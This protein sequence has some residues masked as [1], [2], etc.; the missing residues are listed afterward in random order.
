ML[1]CHQFRV[2]IVIS[3][4]LIV[5]LSV[6]E[7]HFYIVQIFFHFLPFLSFLILL[8]FVYFL[9]VVWVNILIFVV[10][11]VFVFFCVLNNI[12]SCC[13]VSCA[14]IYSVVYLVVICG[15]GYCVRGQF[16][17]MS[18]SGSS[19]SSAVS[20]SISESLL[21]V[22]VSCGC[23]SGGVGGIVEIDDLIGGCST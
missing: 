8:S 2:L 17:W 12:A 18:G 5:L 10:Y 4:M 9:N 21:S 15:G 3:G 23:C 1:N 20:I 13:N 6:Y 11:F 14:S 16:K 19:S 22:S 7:F